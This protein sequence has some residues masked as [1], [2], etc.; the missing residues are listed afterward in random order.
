M[1]LQWYDEAAVTRAEDAIRPFGIP[2]QFHPYL[3]LLMELGTDSR[4]RSNNSR[5]K[6]TAPGLDS[7]TDFVMLAKDWTCALETFDDT[8][9]PKSHPRVLELKKDVKAKRLAMDRYNRYSIHVRGSTPDVYDILKTA[10]FAEEFH[11]LLSVTAVTPDSRD[12]AL[13]QMCPYERLDLGSPFMSWIPM[14]DVS[15]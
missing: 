10:S 1:T 4:H 6:V 9:L 15:T 2:N 12:I 3:T 5:V 8:H 14:Y 13:Q 11:T 7:V